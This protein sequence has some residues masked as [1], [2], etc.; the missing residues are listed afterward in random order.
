MA[1]RLRAGRQVKCVDPVAPEERLKK[2]PTAELANLIEAFC[3]K[4]GQVR[5]SI[6]RRAEPA[7]R[8]GSSVQAI[9]GA[10]AS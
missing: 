9:L 5:T 10:T 1:L 6:S 8:D 2:P 7:D 3:N 4:I